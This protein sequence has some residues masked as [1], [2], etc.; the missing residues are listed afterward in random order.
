M[1]WVMEIFANPGTCLR[2]EVTNE[3]S[4]DLEAVLIAPNGNVYRND[5]SGVSS[6]PNCPLIKVDPTP[7]S[8]RG[9]YTL[10]I[11]QYA[12]NAVNGNFTLLYGL[13]PTGNPACS[14]PTSPSLALD[15][16]AAKANKLG[17][18]NIDSPL[19]GGHNQ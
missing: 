11:S 17:T 12:G 8:T 6:C 1:P 2:L 15:V 16:A 4:N 19:P 13:Y 9:W 5:D 7:G 10:Q 3:G 18:G 14:S